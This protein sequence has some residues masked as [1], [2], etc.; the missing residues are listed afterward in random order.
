MANPTPIGKS[1]VD[2]IQHATYSEM[3]HLARE[4]NISAAALA[5]RLRAMANSLDKPRR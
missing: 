5:R 1:T 4:R 3:E 2:L